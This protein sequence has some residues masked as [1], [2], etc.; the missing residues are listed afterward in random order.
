MRKSVV[1]L[2]HI[3]V[4]T[5][6]IDPPNMHIR[7]STFMLPSFINKCGS[8]DVLDL[9]NCN[10]LLFLTLN[11]IL[12]SSAYQGWGQVQYLYLVLVLKYIFIST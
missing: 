4:L 6:R 9:V 11:N 1:P 3:T 2:I 5:Y 12:Y 7:R 10:N 8:L